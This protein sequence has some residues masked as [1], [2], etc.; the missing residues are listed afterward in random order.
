MSNFHLTPRPRHD[1]IDSK[2]TYRMITKKGHFSFAVRRAKV[3]FFCGHPVVPIVSFV[4]ESLIK[5]KN[6]HVSRIHQIF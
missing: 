2:S 5:I 3:N 4:I 1:P 6:I